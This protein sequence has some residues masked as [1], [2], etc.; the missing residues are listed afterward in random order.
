MKTTHA[1][2]LTV[3]SLCLVLTSVSVQAD[4][5]DDRIESAA[6]KSYVFKHY[7][8]DDSVKVDSKEGVVTL[9]GSVEDASHKSMAQDT[10]EGLPG[11]RRVDNQIE[12]KG[13]SSAEGSDGWITTKVKTA[14]LFHRSVS[15]RRTEVSTMDG[16]VTLRG[17]AATQA[18]KDLATEYAKDING[19]KD[20]KNEMVVGIGSEKAAR[21]DHDNND[22]SGRTVGEKIDDASVTAQAKTALLTHRSTSA[23]RTKV[24]TR[25]GTVTVTGTAKNTAEKDLV[26]KIIGDIEGVKRVDNQMTVEVANK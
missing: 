5:T 23:I 13:T 16:V 26:S 11:V 24:E 12:V 7:L 1:A 10:V 19:V 15:A 17:E 8:R 21:A 18:E 14:L 2:V 4:Q 22:K 6:K 20:V 3:A 25:D 9:R